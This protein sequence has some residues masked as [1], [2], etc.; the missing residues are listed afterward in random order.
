MKFES[1]YGIGDVVY[2]ITDESQTERLITSVE[3]RP[4]HHVYNMVAGTQYS[5]HYEMELSDTKDIVKSLK[6][7]KD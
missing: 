7:E 1:K 4:G 5:A 2:L 3:F 6:Y